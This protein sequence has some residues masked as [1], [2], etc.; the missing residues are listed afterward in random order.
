MS[1]AA[2]AANQRPGRS[3]FLNLARVDAVCIIWKVLRLPWLAHFV[4]QSTSSSSY[5]TSLPAPP[6]N[7]TITH[8]SACDVTITWSISPDVTSVITHFEMT[9]RPLV[10]YSV[11]FSQKVVTDIE[12]SLRTFTFTELFPD[13]EYEI[14]GVSYNMD[15]RSNA[16]ETITLKTL[17]GRWPQAGVIIV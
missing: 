2:S 3:L 6:I 11:P 17:P 4:L 12:G 9:I 10:L 8:I 7:L 14:Y 16:S 13:T 15:Q 1:R 5:L